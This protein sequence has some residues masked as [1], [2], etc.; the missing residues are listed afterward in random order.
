MKTRQRNINA[1]A[2]CAIVAIMLLALYGHHLDPFLSHTGVIVL[3]ISITITVI[4][5]ILRR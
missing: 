2:N 4:V 1:V 3:I 5:Y